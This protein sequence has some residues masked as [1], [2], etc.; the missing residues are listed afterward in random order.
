MENILKYNCGICGSELRVPKFTAYDR[1][2]NTTG[3]VFKII[4]CHTCGVSQTL[5]LPDLTELIQ[6]YPHIYYPTGSTSEMYYKNHIERFQ[7]DKLK[8]IQTYSQTGRL[9]DIGC[10]VGHFIRT[11]LNQG[12]VA[13]G[14]EFSEAAAAVGREQWNL[15]IVSGD[16][17][18]NEFK[19]ESFDII[20]LWQVLEHVR[21]PREVLLKIH[22]LLKPNGLLVIAVPNF[23]SIQAKLFRNRW[24]HLDVPRHLF[25]YSPESLTNI[26]DNCNFRVDNIDYHSS[27]HNY[28]GILGSVMRISPPG[29]SFIH[30]L[31]RKTVA[32][33]FSRVLA[34]LETSISRGGTF[35]AFSRKY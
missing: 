13:E 5:P 8:K 25:H 19:P 6:Y 7:V 32:T 17:L 20:T 28:A 11:A 22:N 31:I 3:R 18:S 2:F 14:V 35:T 34:K 27:E 24:Y 23:A 12:Y 9:L 16:F 21:Q 10:G 4:E 26:L 29:E 1:N 33:S 15:K 30:K